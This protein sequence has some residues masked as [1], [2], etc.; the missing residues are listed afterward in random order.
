MFDVG[1]FYLILA[2]RCSD[3]YFMSRDFKEQQL[4]IRAAGEAV[5]SCE[6]GVG[7]WEKQKQELSQNAVQKHACL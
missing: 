1:R 5:A 2:I 7:I 3:L 6:Y 4:L